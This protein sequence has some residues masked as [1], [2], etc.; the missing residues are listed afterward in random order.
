MS[1]KYETSLGVRFLTEPPEHSTSN[2]DKFGSY[3]YK[4]SYRAYELWPKSKMAVQP[5]DVRETYIDIAGMDGELDLSEVL[6]GYPSYG[7]RDGKFEFTVMDRSHWDYVYSR[8]MNEIH[9]KKMYVILEEDS[10]YYYT[11]RLKVNSFKSKKNTATI[12]VDAYLDPYKVMVNATSELWKWDSFN[13]ETDIARDYLD[14]NVPLDGATYTIIGSK[15]PVRPKFKASANDMTVTING[16]SFN[17]STSY[18]TP[19]NFPVLRD[20]AYEMTFGGYGTVS[21]KFDIG[22]L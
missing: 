13:F 14:L 4:H 12:V 19:T 8:L 18:A 9:G 11:G 17:L 6:T 10:N 7:S 5:P 15:M 2:L 21:I 3:S 1:N 20:E 22:S 16:T